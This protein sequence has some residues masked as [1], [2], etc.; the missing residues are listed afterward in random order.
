MG[1][2]GKKDDTLEVYKE[3]AD[4]LGIP[5]QKQGMIDNPRQYY[6]DNA[7]RYEERSIEGDDITIWAK[8]INDS[9]EPLGYV[10]AALEIDGD[11]FNTFVCTKSDFEKL[12]DLAKRIGH[13][14]DLVQNL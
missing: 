2:L 6:A 12:A 13:R 7:E 5:E 3:I 1:L 11:E 9:W 8:A 4:I 14:I 10:F